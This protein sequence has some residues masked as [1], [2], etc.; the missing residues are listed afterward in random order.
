MKIISLKSKIS[1]VLILFIFCNGIF[2]QELSSGLRGKK[3]EKSERKSKSYKESNRA[4]Q[5]LPPVITGNFSICLPGP[6]TTQLTA[7]LPP[8]VGNP[9]VSSNPTVATID[10]AGLVTQVSFGATTITYT[11]NVG[12]TYSENVYVSAFP[13]INTPNGTSTCAGGVLQIEGSLFPN[14]TT[15]WTSL[16]PAIASVDSSG[17]ITG[18]T[19]GSATIEYK[20]LGGCTTT[21]NVTINPPLIPTITCGVATTNQITFN[22]SAVAGASTYVRSY[23]INGG[24]FLSAGSG[25]ATSYVLTGL[26]PSSTIDFYVAPSGSVGL[27]FQVG[28]VQCFT[29]PCSAATTA[30]APTIG[31]ITP[32]TC[33]L[34]TGSVAISGLPAGNWTLNQLGTATNAIAGNTTSTI[35]SGLT[36]GNYTFTVTN[37]FGCTSVASINVNIPAQPI[38]PAAPTIGIITPPTCALATGS[39]AISGLPAGNWTLNQSGTVVASIAGN[40]TSTTISGLVAGTYTFTVTNS[41]SCT[42][43]ASV[44]VIIPAQPITPAAPTIGIITPPTCAL[45]TGSVDISGLPAG[46]WTLN[47]SG[48]V[49]A[50]IAGNTTSTTISGLVAGNYT[51]T[52]TNAAGCTSLVSVNVPVPVQPI[53]PAIPTIGVITPPNCV[54]ATGSVAISGLPAG[55]WTLDQSGTVINSIVGNTTSTVISGLI[56]GNYTFTVTN[57]V[58][59]TSLVSSNVNI[60]LQPVIPAAPISSGDIVQCEIIPLQTLDANSAVTPPLGQTIIWYDSLVLGSIIL[61]PTLNTIGTVIYYAQANDGTCD[62]ATRTAVTLTINS[63]PAAPI[64][65]GDITQCEQLPIQTLD[66]NSAV[67]PLAGQTIN[68]FDAATLGNPVLLPTLNTVGTITYYAEVNDGTCNSLTRT[69]VKLTISGAPAAPISTGDITQCEQLPIQTLDANNAVTPL[70]GQTITWYDS[71]ALGSIVPLPTLNTVGTI[72]YYAEVN[73][74]TCNSLTRTSVKLT[75]T[76][77]PA[78]PISTGDITQCE[79]LPIQ[80][81]DANNAVTPLP[82]QNITWFAN[83]NG[84]IP[85]TT[86]I[87]STIGTVTYYAQANDGTCNSTTRTSVKLTIIG[88]PAAPISS[89]DITQCEQLPIQTLDANN[90]VT[91]LPGQTINWF[92]AATAGNPVLL[93][94]LNTVGTV[95]Y[96]AE[97]N[98]GTCNST[99]RTSVKLTITGAPAAPIS[100]GNITQCEQLPIQTLNGNSAITVLPGQ[101]ISWFDQLTGGV[102]VANPTL[103]TNASITYYAETKVGSCLSLSRTPL[104]LT[105]NAAPAAPVS[106]G[107]IF[108]CELSPLQTITATATVPAG[109]TVIWYNAPTGGS[110][111]ANPSINTA[112]SVVYF[113]EA[114]DG[115]CPSL[116]RT[117]V[118]LTIN[119]LPANPVVGLLTQPDCFT[120]TGSITI[121]PVP[122]GVSYSFDN[123]PFT[124]TTFYDL[125]PAGTSHT[126]IAKNTGGCLSQTITVNIIPQPA[127]PNA[128]TLTAIQPTCTLATGGVSITSIPG[129]T[130][131][132]DNGPFT[133]TVL[134]SGLIAGSTHTVK[135]KNAAGCISST[136][137]ITLNIQP[138]TPAAPV[139]TPIQPT[140]TVS[141]GTVQISNVLGETYSFDGSPYAA[142][143]IYSGLAS[144]STHNVT[145]K[146][147]SG[148]ISAISSITLGIQPP[149]PPTPT[150]FVAQ[151]N[152]TVALGEVT[153]LNNVGETYS[154]DG[155][156]YASTLIYS[157]L[158]PGNYAITALNGFGCISAVATVT[159]N[160]QPITLTPAILD[161]VICTDQATGIPFKTHILSTGL[162]LATHT[163]AWTLDGA[164]FAASGS[165]IEATEPGIYTVVATNISTGCDSPVAT[166]IVT[167]SFPG[168]G[169]ATQIVNQFSNEAG[170]IVTVNSGTG[171]YLYQLDNGP[172]QQSNVFSSVPPGTHVI[173]VTD[174]NGCTSLSTSV[175]V[176][177]YMNFFTPNNDTFNDNWNVIGLEQQPGTIIHIYDRYGK[178]IKQISANG[179]G[180]DGTFNGQP[181]P[182]TDYWFTVE[183]TE[184]GR[185]KEF[186]SHFSLV[187]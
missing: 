67:S 173:Y 137:S 6:T 105:I 72:T 68:W 153:I 36:A 152:C 5:V 99:T 23:Q 174:E 15:P 115:T 161:G 185:A 140:C 97:V 45:A 179:Q 88:A 143:L 163:F 22:W 121:F 82:G 74:G 37:N 40:T 180:W 91:P 126:I 164:P 104:T 90:A 63:V 43:L 70:P 44:N 117:P 111:V 159:I 89:G 47:Q 71:A 76:G 48:T 123:G 32:P 54:T 118:I 17:L 176:L 156:A 78:A 11:D 24:G 157:N 167:E 170:I 85:I 60:P 66:A 10:A 150:F 120:A 83:A 38:T 51:F 2:A 27:C 52:V 28:Q 30:P 165:S 59:C 96:Y 128:P 46:N 49:V 87:L 31:A 4:I 145:A 16:T 171:P 79:Q 144:G 100:T 3:E 172:V 101:I 61:N 182:S 73:D 103:N 110:T 155:G 114:N 186:K 9:W 19:G 106:G 132:F 93:P 98:N 69:S 130:Y 92:D 124:T 112:I 134:F 138:L 14:A 122:A 178:Y 183:Y 81:L 53:T 42:S 168:L 80:T 84:G 141:T 133:S 64:S 116:T 77:A 65:T 158:E 86:P 39:V 175:T 12:N 119:Q 8:A 35:V 127:T 102:L 1:T 57:S 131:S 166:A 56:G 95:T 162:N 41:V 125:L 7:T 20:N 29:V 184:N 187:R 181:L 129:E 18:I 147:G 113:A 55:N 139:L 50:S 108:Q 142:T 33:G 149:T 151:P 135:A 177:G 62:S 160:P 13:T 148:C 169:I 109:Q 26:L 58:G 136:A 154:F 34:A 146:N 94:T 25:N 107:D 75:I 21:T